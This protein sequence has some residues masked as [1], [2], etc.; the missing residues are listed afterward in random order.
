MTRPF[1]LFRALRLANAV[2]FLAAAGLVLDHSMSGAL[3][4][5]TKD[6]HWATA[7]GRM[8]LVVDNTGDATWHRANQLAVAAWNEAAT[9]SGLRLAWTVGTGDCTAETGRIVVCGATSESL[10]DGAQLTRQGVTRIELGPDREQAHVAVATVLV[11]SDCRLGA[12]RRRVVAA[13][14]LGHALG[15]PHTTRQGSIMY[16]TG[17]PD[18][19]DATDVEGL[20]ALYSHLD[21]PDR[22]GYFDAR[23]GP[24]C[25]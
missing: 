19:P 24:L 25:F 14:E 17:G 9:G 12:H 15:L 13:H 23:V 11:C 1:R 4:R 2:L 3:S 5:L 8:L 16:P 6:A 22:C 7:P 20:R 18:V 10:D 21:A